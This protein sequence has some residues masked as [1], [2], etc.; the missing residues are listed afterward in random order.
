MKKYPGQSKL[1]L[2]GTGEIN[3]LKASIA[4]DIK[5]ESK[6]P[7][8]YEG[9]LEFDGSAK[10]IESTLTFDFMEH[11]VRYGSFSIADKQYKVNC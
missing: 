2:Q 7:W 8:K 11:T 4:G 5:I 1:R 10:N 3:E 6:V 9:S